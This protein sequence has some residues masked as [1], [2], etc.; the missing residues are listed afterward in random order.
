MEFSHHKGESRY[1]VKTFGMYHFACVYLLECVLRGVYESPF[2]QQVTV[3]LYREENGLAL[4]LEY[5]FSLYH[6]R[7]LMRGH[8]TSNQVAVYVCVF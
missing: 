1:S 2:L 5:T 4:G 7:G 6:L 3:L 8:F